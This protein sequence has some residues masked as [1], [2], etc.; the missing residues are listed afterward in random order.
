VPYIDEIYLREAFS[1]EEVAGLCPT[2]RELARVIEMAEAETETALLGGGYGNAVPSSVYA[3]VDACPKAIR[4][5]AFGAW[6]EAAHG[7]KRVPVP[8]Q[9]LEYVRKLDLVRTGRMELPGVEKGGVAKNTA[10]G[11]GGILSTDTTESPP[12]FDRESMRGWG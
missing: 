10:R 3:T 1:E 4:L 6:I 9:Y 2:P 5:L 8:D 7:R 11:P 12:V